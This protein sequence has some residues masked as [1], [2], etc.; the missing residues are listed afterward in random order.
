MLIDSYLSWVYDLGCRVE[1]TWG[2]RRWDADKLRGDPSRR[3]SFV[4]EG[5]KEPSLTV[6]VHF[7]VTGFRVCSHDDSAYGRGCCQLG[8]LWPALKP[9]GPHEPSS[10]TK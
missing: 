6:G 3:P 8:F 4:F 5:Y 7:A 9:R 2:R 1:A 10:D